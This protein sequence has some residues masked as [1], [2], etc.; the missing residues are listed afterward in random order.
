MKRLEDLLEKTDATTK[1][2]MVCNAL[3]LYEWF[4]SQVDPA[5]IAEVR[6]KENNAVY[7]IP[8][9]RLM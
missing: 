1:A 3:K 7:S 9:E 5:Y 8:T 2:E 4:V 6:D